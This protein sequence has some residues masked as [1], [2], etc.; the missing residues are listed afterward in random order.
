MSKDG[1]ISNTILCCFKVYAGAFKTIV[2]T[3]L[4]LPEQVTKSSSKEKGE[5]GVKLTQVTLFTFYFRLRGWFF[6]FRGWFFFTGSSSRGIRLL[7]SFLFKKPN[8]E[9]ITSQIIFNPSIMKNFLLCLIQMGCIASMLLNTVNSQTWEMHFT[10][11]YK[12]ECLW[13]LSS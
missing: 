6:R 12:K 13:C 4:T 1:D 11:Q 3:L 7:A 10:L 5:R 2:Q 9:S 8:G